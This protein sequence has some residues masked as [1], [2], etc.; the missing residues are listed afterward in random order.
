MTALRRPGPRRIAILGHVAR[1]QVRRAVT[2]LRATLAR[3]GREVRLDEMLAAS[4]RV[5]GETGSYAGLTTF[6]PERVL[7]NPYIPPVVLT[8]FQLSDVPARIGGDSPLR[9]SIC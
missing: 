9:Q 2:R 1:P 7:E 6:F 8:S 3:Q 4:E 5:F